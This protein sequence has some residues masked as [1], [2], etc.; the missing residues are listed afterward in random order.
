MLKYTNRT[1]RRHPALA[2]ALSLMLG[3]NATS[4]LAQDN[5]D[6]DVLDNL[7][8]FEASDKF[9]TIKTEN[10][11]S[12][13]VKANG[14]FGD[15]NVMSVTFSP[16]TRYSGIRFKPETPWDWSELKEY[17]IAVDLKNT[18]SESL[19][20]YFSLVDERGDE[21]GDKALGHRAV[22][23]NRSTN[24]APGESG[25]YFAILDGLFAE[26][27]AGIREQP[28]PWATNDEMFYWR[29]GEKKINT[30]NVAQLALFVRGNLTQ[31]SIEVD[32]FRI[33]K[34]PDYDM[35]Y[36]EGFVDE[37]GQ[38]SRQSFP[39]KIE[40]QSQLREIANKELKKLAKSGLM[41][42]RSRFG[43][44]KDGPKLEATGYFRTQKMGDQWWM[45]DPDGYL[46]FSHGVANVRMAN[47]T[48][49][50]GVDFKDS[51]VRYVD[52][53]EVTP[54]DSIGMVEVSDEARKSKFISSELR[55]NMFTWL[56]SY[57]DE[58]A[59]HYSYR[60]KVLRGPMTSGETF[61]FYRANLERRYGQTS[62][63]SYI[64]KWEEVTLARMQD[65]G[66]TSM[67]NWV[68]PAF[69]PNEKVPYFANGW[70]IGDF[71]TL[72]SKHDVWSP[73]PDAFDPEFVKRAQ[74]TVD[75]IAKEIKGSPWC[76]GIFVDNEKSWGF[77]KG[78]TEQRYGVIL[79]ALSRDAKQSPAKQAFVEHLKDKYKE[80]S[81]LNKAWD[82]NFE[83]WSNVASGFELESENQAFMAD[84][85]ALLEM[86]SERYFN[87]VHGAVE[88]ALPNHLY[89]G[90]RMANWGM[91][92]ETIKAA[93][94]YSDV[95][96]FNIYDEGIQ[97]HDWA[98]L[99]EI[100]LPSVIGEFH[101]GATNE[102]GLFHPGLVQADDQKDRARMYLNYMQS[103][104]DHK[105]MV[106]AHWFQ[107]IDSPVTGRAI[108]GEPYNVGF[109]S[110][111][112]IPYKEMVDAA[113]Q[114]NSALYPK[115]F[116]QAIISNDKVAH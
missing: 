50:T 53:N 38:N 3:F 37:F 45:V 110:N 87:V 112:D 79:N 96:S 15:G 81:E 60:R 108:D 8:A 22:S 20:I 84:L 101:I 86:L 36:L 102:T 61:N 98:F 62:P 31:K 28:K 51:S 58:L 90:A 88:K 70:I 116:K 82:A 107:Y 24:L 68:D 91:P 99:K 26:T 29:Y 114:F 71:K 41:K 65:W 34:N 63:E 78:T 19:Q 54:E 52:P 106:G 30:S 85:S 95:L 115:R 40:S 69:Y 75:V 12:K 7:I 16:D 25:T 109:V 103:V 33:R 46:F 17:H 47:L 66:F 56:P 4:A 23:S 1:K 59:D 42:D 93:V 74:I 67:G 80:V 57:D 11:D 9:K 2:G 6:T 35:S 73:M 21:L 94:K 104:A 44:W 43:G 111:T 105:N 76:V 14:K 113:K 55:N 13:I 64:R 83:A 89:M 49:L 10:V 77:R 48:T 27:D 100:D 97:A 72:T 18:S 5:T 39:I 32:N 92:D